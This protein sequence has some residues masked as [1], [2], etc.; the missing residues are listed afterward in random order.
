MLNAC[1]TYIIGFGSLLIACV[2]LLSCR[3]RVLA[4]MISS[5]LCHLKDKFV[6]FTTVK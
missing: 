4:H 2:M 5:E 1:Y 3:F 6:F